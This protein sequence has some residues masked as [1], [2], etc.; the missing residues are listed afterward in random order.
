MTTIPHHD[1]AVML[2]DKARSAKD[3]LTLAGLR[4]GRHR[5]SWRHEQTD[6]RE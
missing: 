2:Q 4:N 1:T 6:L 5:S 3:H